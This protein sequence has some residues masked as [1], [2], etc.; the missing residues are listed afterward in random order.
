[1]IKL[2]LTRYSM[3]FCIL[4]SKLRRHLSGSICGSMSHTCLQGADFTGAKLAAVNFTDAAVEE[5][6]GTLAVRYRDDQG[7]QTPEPPD[8]M[9]LN[10]QATK[11]FDLVWLADDF[12]CPNGMTVSANQAQGLSLQQMLISATAPTLQWVPQD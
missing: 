10:Y 1:M 11:G 2:M 7:N 3:K 6:K 4:S 9:P 12:I 8:F 5:T